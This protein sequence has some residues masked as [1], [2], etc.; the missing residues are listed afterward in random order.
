MALLV[1][2]Q[3]GQ[4]QLSTDRNQRTEVRLMAHWVGGSLDKYI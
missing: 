1:S 2:E 4:V 3:S